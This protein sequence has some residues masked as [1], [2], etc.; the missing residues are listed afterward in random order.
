MTVREALIKALPADCNMA[1]I[2]PKTTF[3]GRMKR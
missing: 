3:F 1:W 2:L